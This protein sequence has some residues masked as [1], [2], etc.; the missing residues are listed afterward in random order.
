MNGGGNSAKPKEPK[1]S[2]NKGSG[3]APSA[4]RLEKKRLAKRNPGSQT[5]FC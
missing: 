1:K 3:A 2:A 4:E 5:G